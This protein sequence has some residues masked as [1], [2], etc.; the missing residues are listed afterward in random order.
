VSSGSFEFFDHTGDVGIRLSGP[1][2]ESVFSAA[3]Q[4]LTD[5]ITGLD[6]VRA[7]E[8][9]EVR[10]SASS[11]DLLLVDWMSELLFEFDGRGWLAA[12]ADVALHS[13]GGVQHLEATVRGEAADPARHHIHILVKAVTY[14][15]LELTSGPHGWS[16][17]VVL[18]I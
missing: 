12:E 17:R 15:G 5:T 18:D 14:H 4:A 13:G 3:A 11:L 16:A 2:P 6:Q 7:V 9:K 1:T 8:A 10:L